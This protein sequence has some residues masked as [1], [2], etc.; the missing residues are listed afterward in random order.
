MANQF[1]ARIE[2]GVVKETTNV[3]PEGRYHPDLVWVPASPGVKQMD[4]YDSATGTF[5]EFVPPD[6]PEPVIEEN[7]ASVPGEFLE[8]PIGPVPD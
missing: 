7:G 4:L 3:N 5:S 1:W 2:D 6:E 8:A